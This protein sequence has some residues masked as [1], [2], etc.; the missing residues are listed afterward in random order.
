LNSCRSHHVRGHELRP[1]AT[2]LP[3]S[4]RALLRSAPPDWPASCTHCRP[5]ALASPP[6]LPSPPPNNPLSPCAAAFGGG[7]GGW[8]RYTPS[9]PR[10]DEPS[11]AATGGFAG[12]T[13]ELGRPRNASV[14]LNQTPCRA[15]PSADLYCS[16]HPLFCRLPTRLARPGQAAAWAPTGSFRWRCRSAAAR[17]A[18]AG[19][20]AR[21][22]AASAGGPIRRPPRLLLWARW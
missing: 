5:H 19:P 6:A 8:G 22:R 2:L 16:P 13:R 14:A 7:A 18:G 4:P 21:R 20:L 15:P 10:P 3:A 12:E 9:S 1:S 17:R 11:T